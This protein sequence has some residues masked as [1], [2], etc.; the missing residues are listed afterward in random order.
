MNRRQLLAAGALAAT[1]L[2]ARAQPTPAPAPAPSPPRRAL[3][4]VPLVET[5]AL[6][7]TIV[8]EGLRFPEGPV[9]AKDGSLYFVQID[10]KQVCRLT[11]AGKVE[12]LAEPGGGPNGLAVGPDGHIWIANNG[13]RFT[14]VQRDGFTVSGPP[15][16]GFT[17]G[18]RI[19]RMDLRTGKVETLFDSIDSKPL[20]APDDLVFDRAGGLWVT[21]FGLGQGTGA[22]YY[23]APGGKTLTLARGGMN[24]PNGVGVSPDGKLLHVSMGT[25]LYAFDIAGPGKLAAT[26]YPDGRQ[27]GLYQGSFADSLRLQADGKVCVCSLFR[28]GG[29]S[30]IDRQG[31]VEFLGFPDRMVCSLA[32]G[33]RDMRDAWLMLSGLGKIAKVRWPAPGQTPAFRI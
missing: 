5:P 21:E 33:G 30:V 17:G 8:A 12:V 28:P 22:L 29:V 6:P 7:M 2:G 3:P 4:P 23:A 25:G 10:A 14:F 32:F 20:I 18:G 19:Q 16:A 27:A 1:P 26:T 11:P 31:G 24:A 13:G 15:P 9:A